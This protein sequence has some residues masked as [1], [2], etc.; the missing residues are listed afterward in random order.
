MKLNLPTLFV[1]ERVSLNLNMGPYEKRTMAELEGAGCINH[2]WLCVGR[3]LMTSRNT[4]LR[5]FFDGCETPFVEAPAGDFFG[6]MHG[7]KFYP[8][9]TEYLAVMEESGYNCYFKMPFARGARIELETGAQSVPVFIMVDWHRYPQGDMQE[10]YRFCARWRRENPTERYGRDFLILDADG[11]GR[12][13]G[14]VYGVRLHDNTDRWSH[15]GSE[16]IY[17]DGEGEY[18]AYIRGIG[19]EDTFGTSYGGALHHS[20]TM[21]YASMPYYVHED[22]GEA[23]PAQRLTGYRFYIKDSIEFRGSIQMRF[24][25]MSNEICSTVYWYA[26]SEVRDFFRMPAADSL[27]PNTL[28]SGEDKELPD[29]GEW[30]ICGP[31]PAAKGFDFE[32]FVRNRENWQFQKEFPL[33]SEYTYGPDDRSNARWSVYKANHGFVDFRHNMRV[34]KR[35]VS[36]T[37]D[38]YGVAACKLKTSSATKAVLRFAWDDELWLCLNGTIIP[39]GNHSSFHEKQISVDLKQGE[40]DLIVCLS[41]TIGFNHGGWCFAFS[42]VTQE[43]DVIRPAVNLDHCHR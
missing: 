23:R 41:N 39:M 35:G 32:D 42:A 37:E 14:F 30:D 21:L 40:N 4:I 22:V 12:L 27:M 11:P 13:I 26:K 6:V 5:I 9:N 20:E 3:R 19:G 18:P 28:S 8:I 43:G 15:G 36:P 16:N 29:C 7:E 25:C 38:G 17:I 2:I 24:G 31:F 10:E 33:Y 34:R 1:N